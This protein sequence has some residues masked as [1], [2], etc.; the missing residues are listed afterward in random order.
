VLANEARDQAER[1]SQQG[2]TEAAY[3][4]QQA[5]EAYRKGQTESAERLTKEANRA[6]ALN[7]NN[8]VLPADQ[9]KELETLRSL[10]KEWIADRQQLLN[11]I[12]ALKRT[13]GGGSGAT[14]PDGGG[15]FGTRPS[16]GGGGTQ[17]GAG[18]TGRVTPPIGGTPSNAGTSSRGGAAS[19]VSPND[20]NYKAIYKEAINSRDRRRWADAE[21]RF[22]SAAA[23]K[24]DS[25]ET[26]EM[27]SFGNDQPYLPFYNLGVVLQNQTKCAEALAAWAAAEQA[28]AVKQSK[29][30]DDLKKRRAQCESSKR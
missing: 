13:S 19:N 10:Q 1:A 28:G 4:L 29:F 20:A 21:R 23:I 24:P 12:D 25:G 9:V 26:I 14:P 16:D 22:R 8:A 30:Y 15:G 6:S 7:A 27:E 18:L 5:A 2:K 11:Q 17:P 3:L